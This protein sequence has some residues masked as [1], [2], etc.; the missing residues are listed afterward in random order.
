MVRLN[1]LFL[2]Y[3][4]PPQK[5]P[6]SIQ[7][8]HLVQHLQQYF[9]I[10]VVTSEPDKQYDR[11]LLHFTPLDN[12]RYASKS[13][14]TKFVENMKGHRIKKALLPDVQYLWHFDLM[15]KASNIINNSQV[16]MIVTFGQPMSTH[17]SGLKL[18]QQY[19]HLKWIAHFSDPW[20]DNIFNNYNKWI[21]EV[22]R[23]YQSKVFTHADQLLFTSFE[24]ID[25]VTK[26]YPDV[27]RLKSAY[28]P[29]MFNEA[30]YKH[31]PFCANKKF[32]IRYLGNFYGN[33][34]PGCL[35][36]ALQ[37][38]PYKQRTQIRL[39]LIGSSTSSLQ[40]MMQDYDLEDIVYIHS[41]MSYIDSLESM[42]T[43]DLLLIIDAPTE[44]SPFLPSKLIDYIGANKP[45]FGITS[46]GPSQKLIEEMGFLVAHPNDPV[47][48]ANKL[49]LMIQKI[50]EGE[51]CSVPPRLRN[52]YSMTTVG[53]QM[54]DIIYKLN[55]R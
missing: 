32:R 40:E 25:L 5:F 28:V 49:M 4:Y 44:I 26:N 53:A 55:Q 3:A 43:A 2:T 14:L 30:L 42:Q 12:V 29:H 27:I 33:R 10:T 16:D 45:I 17:I 13:K 35:F 47:D 41:S 1:I 50:Q 52:R 21:K 37:K 6:R 8:S 7:I 36:Q 46:P 18:K 34:Q 38:L 48:I 23:Y 24:T 39:E 20:V 54:K 22:N 31:P 15:E 19:P 51:I 11:S 9:N